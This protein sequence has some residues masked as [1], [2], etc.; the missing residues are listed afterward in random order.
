MYGPVSHLAS[1]DGINA[2]NINL[3]KSGITVYDLYTMS[4]F[5]CS[6]SC[7]KAAIATPAPAG[8]LCNVQANGI[9]LAGSG[10][11]ASYTAGSPY[12]VSIEECAAVCMRIETCTN[13]L[14]VVGKNCDLKFGPPAY[15]LNHSG[16]NALSLFDMSCFTCIY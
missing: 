5:T 13:V 6:T 3:Q 8:S 7:Y 9:A 14:F 16:G 2:H 10:S 12:T 4:C 1:I 15:V 11:L